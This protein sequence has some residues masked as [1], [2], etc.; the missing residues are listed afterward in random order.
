MPQKASWPSKGLKE[1]H[2]RS[3]MYAIVQNRKNQNKRLLSSLLLIA[4]TII[5]G[6][7][8]GS[9]ETRHHGAH[10]HGMAK[11]N[12]ALDGNELLLELTSP[13]ANIVGFEHAPGTEKEKH[14]VHEAV[15]LLE[16]GEK[17]FSF[18]AGAECRLHEARVIS[19]MTGEHHDEEDR[20]RKEH[21]KPHKGH[22]DA[23]KKHGHQDEEHIENHTEEPH[24][25]GDVHSEFQVTYHFECG[26]PD[27]LKSVDVLLFSA[28]PGFEEIEVQLLTREIQTG[29]ELSSKKHKLSF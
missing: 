5:C 15:E 12:I 20:D 26:N 24:G 7:G 21:G 4:F 3:G 22:D 18:T 10:V 25:Q 6:A 13:A 27:R 9:A 28:F 16:D 2:M 8:L 23:P 1:R 19:D 17:M 14:A 11:L 29:L